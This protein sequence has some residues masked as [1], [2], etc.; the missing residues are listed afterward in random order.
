MDYVASAL[1]GEFKLALKTRCGL[2]FDDEFLAQIMKKFD[3]DGSGVIDYRK[4]A[5]L[6][7]GSKASDGTSAVHNNLSSAAG[8][9]D[10]G[11]TCTSNPQHE[12]MPGDIYISDRLLVCFQLPTK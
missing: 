1:Q 2:E 12:L 10:A 9:D 4:F 3:D 8:T 5:T 7:M 11:S 6:V